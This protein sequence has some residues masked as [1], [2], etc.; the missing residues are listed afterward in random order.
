M[1]LKKTLLKTDDWAQLC[2]FVFAFLVS[3]FTL[4]LVGCDV[5]DNKVVNIPPEVSVPE[6]YENFF[7]E[8]I[9]FDRSADERK[10]AFQIN[11]GWVMKV[12]GT[13]GSSVSWCS[14]ESN[15]GDAGLHK[16]LVRVTENNTYELRSAK[17]QLMCNE[18]KV[19]EIVIIQDY[20][21]AILLDMKTCNISFDDT[22]VNIDMKSNVEFECEVLDATW[23]RAK[24]STTRA[25]TNHCLVFE[26]DENTSRE[27][28]EAH[29]R[30]YNIDHNINEVLTLVQKGNPSIWYGHAESLLGE[31]SREKY[32]FLARLTGDNHFYEK[33][34]NDENGQH[35][36]E[37][38]KIGRAHV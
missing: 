10:V 19:A 35:H 22:S 7:V 33:L 27:D 4:C 38:I 26:V 36:F 2:S 24:Q 12:V 9:S 1:S 30:F 5:E 17:L 23:I 13:D 11:V 31:W 14:V 20:E 34:Y 32:I 21:N 16:V 6:G 25:L 37:D 18:A 29:I 3:S 28:R 8:D 15:S